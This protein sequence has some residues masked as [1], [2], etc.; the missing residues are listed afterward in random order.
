VPNL[1]RAFFDTRLLNPHGI[2]LLWRPDLL[3]THV[4]S[5]VVIGLAY[6]SI[7]LALGVLLYRRREVL[8]GWAVWMF[9][10]FIMLCGVTHFMSVWT[11]WHADYGVE[12]LI[13]AATAAVSLATAVALWPLLPR[14]IA[15][16]ST[17]ALET[18]V[19]E[20]DEALRRLEAA[21]QTMVAMEEHQAQQARLLAEL[22]ATEAQLRSVVDNAAVGIARVAL[23]GT[24]LEIND[25]Y[26][27]IAGWPREDML[28]NGFQRITHPDDLETDLQH[29]DDL[30]DG[31]ADWY[32]MEKR[33]VRADGGLVWVKLTASIVRKRDGAPDHFVAIVE[34][35]SE[36]R[37][38]REARELLMREVDHRA[39]NALTVVQS[40]IRLTDAADPDE[41]RNVVIGRI[42]ALAR[43][44]GALS[45]SNWEGALVSDVV[46]QELTA[47]TSRGNVELRGPKR[48][49]PPGDVQPL[50]M[51]VHELATN[52]AKYGS[53]SQQGGRVVV[54]WTDG[55]GGGVNLRWTETDGPAVSPPS[56]PGFGTR[57][58][59]RLSVQLSARPEFNWT[60][61]GLHFRLFT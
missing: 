22:Q 53:L 28:A 14:V 36:E 15:L 32:A 47:I 11:L 10:A 41:F 8:F 48:M 56:Q 18:R 3:W 55:A 34:D 24:F 2:C 43:A 60:A 31:R 35:I 19:G 44:Q 6:F 37:R 39:R 61:G 9:V 4:V 46:A 50:G 40:V 49:L 30:I 17:Q 5:D 52:A 57:L 12:A 7:P 33:Y 13:K 16:P 59:E 38:A 58:I 23:D 51:I 54:D 45:R 20:R 27:Q 25:R 42:D 26:S 1:L 29:V 21:M